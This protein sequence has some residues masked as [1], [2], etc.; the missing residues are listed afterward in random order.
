MTDCA[1]V[2]RL[3]WGAFRLSF[4]LCKR[5]TL[6]SRNHFH[7]SRFRSLALSHTR[8]HTH[9]IS[10]RFFN[11][12]VEPIYQWIP[13]LNKRVYSDKYERFIDKQYQVNEDVDFMLQAYKW[14]TAND[15][16]RLEAGRR[17][18]SNHSAALH[19][20]PN[21][22]APDMA[23]LDDEPDEERHLAA[24]AAASRKLLANRLNR[25]AKLGSDHSRQLLDS[26]RAALAMEEAD[27]SRFRALRLVRPTVELDG[28]YTCSISSLDGDDLK[29][30]RL[31]VYGK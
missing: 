4:S 25:L 15:G 14:L 29:S 18:R 8:T 1:I 3:L 26:L 21:D 2:V 5:N 30:T 16:E 19:E 11:D 13:D 6:I 24:A 17:A 23:L 9:T 31:I 12:E 28:R 7:I 22:L 27:A 20:Q 10:R